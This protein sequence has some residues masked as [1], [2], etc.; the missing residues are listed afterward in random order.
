MATL[1]AALAWRTS[2]RT[3]SLPRLQLVLDF[4]KHFCTSSGGIS[5]FPALCPDRSSWGSEECWARRPFGAGIWA[6]VC[7][8]A[9]CTL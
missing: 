1:W 2:H 7:S 6:K 3:R 9:E 5:G 8:G 4:G